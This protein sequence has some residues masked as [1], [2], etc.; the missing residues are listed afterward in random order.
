MLFVIP[1]IVFDTI[2]GGLLTLG[3]YRKS[4][5]YRKH[6]PLIRLIIHDGLLYFAFVFITNIVWILVQVFEYRN[7][8]SSLSPGVI[9]F[10][11][12]KF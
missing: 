10:I 7:P 9:Y 1:A 6:M 5:S 3:L 12:G 4:G 8:V 11:T 2:V